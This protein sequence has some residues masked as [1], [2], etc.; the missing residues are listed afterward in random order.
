MFD[1]AF[2]VDDCDATVTDRIEDT[3]NYGRSASRSRSAA[4]E[5]SYKTLERL[6]T[7]VADRLMDRFGAESVRVGGQ[8]RATN[9][10]A[11]RRG[12]R[13]GVEGDLKV[14][15]LGLGSN[16]GDRLRN[17]RAAREALVLYEVAVRGGIVGVR[18]RPLRARCSTSRT[19]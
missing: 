13:R 2:D 16:E 9:P 19:S 5:R 8:A 11:G 14:G 17:L 3:V 6:C 10:A 7:A 12:L 1:I 4:Q 15:Y 18:D